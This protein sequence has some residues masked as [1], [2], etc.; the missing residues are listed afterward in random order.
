M[1]NIFLEKL[2]HHFVENLIL[3]KMAEVVFRFSQ[4]FTWHRFLFKLL[5]LNRFR[6]FHYIN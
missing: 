1:Q 3:Y 6:I 5:S 4:W 2:P